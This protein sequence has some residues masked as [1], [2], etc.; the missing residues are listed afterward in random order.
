MATPRESFQTN[1]E[2]KRQPVQFRP[3]A[4]K[5]ELRET[6]GAFSFSTQ[7]EARHGETQGA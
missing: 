6:K 4:L 7:E 5:R 3:A 2:D 1:R